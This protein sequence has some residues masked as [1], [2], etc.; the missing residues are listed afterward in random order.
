[1]L[2]EVEITLLLCAWL[3][4]SE[5]EVRH[6]FPNLGG[7]RAIRVDC[8]TEDLVIEVGLD[9]K[10]S[11]RDSVHQAIVASALTGKVPMVVLVDRDGQ[12][13]RYE[14]ETRIVAAR[15][16]VHYARCS[17]DFIQRWRMTQPLRRDPGSP[18][19]DLPPETQ[20]WGTCDI[21]RVVKAA[22]VF[23][24]PG[25]QAAVQPVPWPDSPPELPPLRRVSTGR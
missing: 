14:Q 6:S 20:V 16:G 7:S 21:A 22:V 1:M 2:N 15:A 3:A 13:G 8:E 24:T 23:G 25:C 9:D 5:T 10:A 12:E 4:G 18:I 11:S 17:R 19:G